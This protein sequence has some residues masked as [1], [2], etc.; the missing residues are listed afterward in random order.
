M[1]LKQ[2]SITIPEIMLVAG[3]RIALGFG[4]GL[5]LSDRLSSDQR[6]AAG[7]ALVGVGVITTIPIVAGILGKPPITERLEDVDA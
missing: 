3:T 2:R 1:D 5:L 6:R 7:W 4:L